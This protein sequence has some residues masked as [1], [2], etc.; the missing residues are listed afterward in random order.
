LVA[1]PGLAAVRV[2]SVDAPYGPLPLKGS[3]S[4]A[5][6]LQTA[7]LNLARVRRLWQ[8]RAVL[9]NDVDE[10]VISRSGRS[11]F[12][13]TAQSRAGWF[14]FRGLWRAPVGGADSAAR[15]ADHYGVLDDAKPYPAKY[16]IVP[17]GPMRRHSW[18]VHNLDLVP[19]SRWLESAEFHYLHCRGITTRWKGE[20]SRNPLGDRPEDAEAKAL[21][22]RTLGSAASVR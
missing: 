16:C 12:D 22:A 5:L 3:K 1:V 8:A 9:Q 11:I 21:L 6:Y 18:N 20:K 7:L 14:K 17:A 19:F 2:A 4:K 10:L 13:A 15:H